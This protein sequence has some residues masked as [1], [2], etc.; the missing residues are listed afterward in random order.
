M[1][2]VQRTSASTRTEAMIPRRKISCEL[3]IVWLAYL[4][5]ES[6]T[7]KQPMATHM[8]R[9]PRRLALSRAAYRGRR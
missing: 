4:T 6:L 8:N 3:A 1:L 5:S 9:M 2:P 7:T